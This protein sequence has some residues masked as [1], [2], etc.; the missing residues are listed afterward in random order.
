MFT[1]IDSKVTSF[2]YQR[3]DKNEVFGEWSV[4]SKLIARF[5]Q[6]WTSCLQ[7]LAH[8]LHFTRTVSKLTA[9]MLHGVG[10]CRAT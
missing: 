5:G 8:T 3:M 2:C 10:I 6:S 7:L 4:S 1:A 9:Y